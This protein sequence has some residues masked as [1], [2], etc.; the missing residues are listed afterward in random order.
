MRNNFT[1]TDH[2]TISYFHTAPDDYLQSNSIVT[3]SSQLLSQNVSVA[4]IDDTLFESQESF[5][6]QLELSFSDVSDESVVFTNRTARVNIRD[7]D[8]DGNVLTY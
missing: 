5:N 4:I 8:A 1:L 6:V 2:S 7:N 3:F